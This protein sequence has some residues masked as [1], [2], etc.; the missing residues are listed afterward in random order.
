MNYSHIKHHRYLLSS[1]SSTKVTVLLPIHSP[2]QFMKFLQLC[3]TSCWGPGGIPYHSYLYE[4]PRGPGPDSK[5]FLTNEQTQHQENLS[6]E[7][8]MSSYL[9][10]FC[11]WLHC[12]LHFFTSSGTFLPHRVEYI[13]IYT[14]KILL[15]CTCIIICH[16]VICVLWL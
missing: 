1:R 2:P 12:M 7:I 3:I 15:R 9:W 8:Q 16:H 6:T 10:N 4:P 5:E 14:Y 11:H 13:Y